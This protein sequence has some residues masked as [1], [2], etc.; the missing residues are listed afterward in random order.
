MCLSTAIRLWAGTFEHNGKSSVFSHSRRGGVVVGRVRLG[1]KTRGHLAAI[2]A[3]RL[4]MVVRIDAQ[5]R[6]T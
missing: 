5:T 6:V 3:M 1:M 4:R 2:D